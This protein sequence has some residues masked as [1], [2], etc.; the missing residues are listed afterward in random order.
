V[1]GR[2]VERCSRG[3][4]ISEQ[5]PT[6]RFVV[7]LKAIKVCRIR[8]QKPTTVPVSFASEYSDR[9]NFI[10]EKMLN[11]YSETQ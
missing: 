9:A 3:G 5:C 1:T 4:R 6:D 2:I 8:S 10:D 11:Y 7:V